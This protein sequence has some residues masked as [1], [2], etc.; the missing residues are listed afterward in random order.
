[1]GVLLR[2]RHLAPVGEI[3][4]L[5]DPCTHNVLDAINR[6]SQPRRPT[7]PFAEV[8]P[9]LSPSGGDATSAS[10]RAALRRRCDSGRCSGPAPPSTLP[11][12]PDPLDLV[13]ERK[14]QSRD[15]GLILRHFAT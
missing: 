6:P 12:N 2:T 13:I 3:S 8:R 11:P 9:A 5:I 1:M 7:S 10:C 15:Q 4:E 14:P